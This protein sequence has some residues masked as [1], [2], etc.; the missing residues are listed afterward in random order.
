MTPNIVERWR[1]ATPAT[2]GL[3]VVIGFIATINLTLFGIKEITGG[4]PS[5][6]SSSSYATA[7]DGVGAYAELLARNG[8]SVS[9]I[10]TAPSEQALDPTTTVVVLDPFEVSPEDGR[11]L[12]AFLK[13]GGKLVASEGF[14]SPWLKDVLDDP[15]AIGENAAGTARPLLPDVFPG[16]QRVRHAGQGAWDDAGETKAIFGGDDY[17]LVTSAEVDSGSVVLLADTSPLTNKLLDQADN[18]AFGLALAGEPGS[19]VQFLETIHG[20][21]TSGGL[22]ALPSQWR[23]SLAGLAAAALVYMVARGRR[24]GPPEEESRSLPPPRRA[25]VDALAATLV[26]TRDPRAAAA[27]IQRSM[28]DNLARRTG[29]RRST[30]DTGDND[31]DAAAYDDELR[32]AATRIGIDPAAIEA[33]L[34]AVTSNDDLLAAGTALAQLKER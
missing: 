14:A 11:A 8:H 1:S 31:A 25:Y 27:P 6:Q 10:R 5:G 13:N 29:L 32:T 4:E 22:G 7:P 2:R 23:W 34:G 28:R 17:V 33:A 20:Y 19:T 15:P 21:G 9:R 26:K 30:H 18:A 24:L 16:V 3:V 12:R